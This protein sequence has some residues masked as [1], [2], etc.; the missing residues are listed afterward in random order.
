MSKDNSSI[1]SLEKSGRFLELKD[2]GGVYL[3]FIHEFTKHRKYI[4]NTINF[5]TD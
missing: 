2:V 1:A 4:Y 3:G 5:N